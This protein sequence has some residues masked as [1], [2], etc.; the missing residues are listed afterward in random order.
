[1]RE[2]ISEIFVHLVYWLMCFFRVVFLSGKTGEKIHN[3]VY[4]SLGR[5]T[6]TQPEHKRKFE[7][8]W[9]GIIGKNTA[10]VEWQRRVYSSAPAFW[11]CSLKG[12]FARRLLVGSAWRRFLKWRGYFIPTRLIISLNSP[13]GGCN[14]HCKTCF[15]NDGPVAEM[16][17]ALLEKILRDQEEIGVHMVT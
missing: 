9:D 14:L 3:L 1:M 10:F 6:A 11:K 4:Y 17:R 5:L 7:M 15:A 13:K 16:P 8:L 12:V 2:A